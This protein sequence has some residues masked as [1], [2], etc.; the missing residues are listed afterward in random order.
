MIDEKEKKITLKKKKTKQNKK[1]IRIVLCNHL[2]N[3]FSSFCSAFY[4]IHNHTI[5]FFLAQ[6]SSKNTRTRFFS[7]VVI[8]DFRFENKKQ[9]L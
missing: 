7:S 4:L 6:I 5:I 9:K 2:F 1:K 3:I 8:D